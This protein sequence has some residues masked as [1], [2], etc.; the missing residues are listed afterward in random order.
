M[1][2]PQKLIL[3]AGLYVVALALVLAF[4]RSAHRGE[5]QEEDW[6]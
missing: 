1:T 6:I 2:D 3:L 4:N 5:A